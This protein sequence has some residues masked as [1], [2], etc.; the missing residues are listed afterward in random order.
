METKLSIINFTSDR[1]MQKINEFN[2]K[3]NLQAI[4]NGKEFKPINISEEG[5]ELIELISLDCT[6]AT[7]KWQGDNEIKIDKLG[8]ISIDSKKTKKIWNGK[9]ESEKKPLRLK[10]RNISGDETVIQ[11]TIKN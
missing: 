3:G 10:I 9:I 6:N 2:E 1:L 11:L 5:L 4:S 7:G 8:Y